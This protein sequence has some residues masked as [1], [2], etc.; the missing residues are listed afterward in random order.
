M[1]TLTKNQVVLFAEVFPHDTNRQGERDNA[2]VSYN[3]GEETTEVGGWEEGTIAQRC[4]IHDRPIHAHQDGVE[5]R[6]F[7]AGS[8]GVWAIERA[9]GVLSSDHKCAHFK[10]IDE[11]T[12]DDGAVVFCVVG[13]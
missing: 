10:E 11:R 7:I 5:W 3:T 1:Y 2:C 4:G 12:K 6:D 9:F 8:A 13:G